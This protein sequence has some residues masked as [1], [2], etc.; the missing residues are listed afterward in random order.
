MKASELIFELYQLIEKHGDLPVVDAEEGPIEP[1]V[2]P[3]EVARG[4][5][6]PERIKLL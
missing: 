2:M 1:F 6:R 5:L 4:L 3:V